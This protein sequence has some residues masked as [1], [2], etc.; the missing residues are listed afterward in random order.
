MSQKNAARFGDDVDRK[1]VVEKNI[2]LTA[3]DQAETGWWFA[4]H[5]KLFKWLADRKI[6]RVTPVSFLALI[7]AFVGGLMIATVL[8]M[9]PNGLFGMTVIAF[10]VGLVW[11]GLMALFYV[12]FVM[13]DAVAGVWRGSADLVQ[14]PKRPLRKLSLFMWWFK[15]VFGCLASTGLFASSMSLAQ[16]LFFG[17]MFLL[18]VGLHDFREIADEFQREQLSRL[19]WFQFGLLSKTSNT[20]VEDRN[21][22]F[23]E[24]VRREQFKAELADGESEVLQL[25][26]KYL[27]W[28]FAGW[29][30]SNP[31]SLQIFAR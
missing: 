14:Q 25:L 21:I 10:C 2:D 20:E 3:D 15:F 24:F 13:K 30:L 8:D 4:R 22:A 1:I 27:I 16:K 11:V 7:P 29:L 23:D 5:S 9:P 19:T 12:S 6:N 18:L 31:S 17:A 28:I 26:M